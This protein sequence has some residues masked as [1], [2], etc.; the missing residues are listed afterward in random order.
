[1]ESTHRLR[2]LPDLDTSYADQ[3]KAAKSRVERALSVLRQ[4]RE[5]LARL[6]VI[7][8]DQDGRTH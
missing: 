7:T 3:L 8:E 2:L 5:Q 4:E 6:L 1:M